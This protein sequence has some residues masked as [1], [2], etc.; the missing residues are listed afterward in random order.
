[1]FILL[2]FHTILSIEVESEKPLFASSASKS[3]TVFPSSIFPSLSVQPVIY[4]IASAR[5]VFPDPPC[6]SN[7]IFLILF[8]SKLAI[9]YLLPFDCIRR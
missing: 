9:G 3:E 4:A 5:E 1:M 2:S 8:V 6:P 7:T